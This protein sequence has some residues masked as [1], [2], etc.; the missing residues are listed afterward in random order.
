MGKEGSLWDDS[1]L[2][3]AFDHAISTYKKMDS[4]KNKHS[5]AEPERVMD[6]GT[7]LNDSS[8]EYPYYHTTRDVDKKSNVPATDAP[9]SGENTYAS[10]LEENHL[11]ESRVDLPHLDSTSSQDIQNVQN[12]YAYAQGAD[13]YNQ[14]VAKY[15]E[16]EDKKLKVLEQ[17]NQYGCSNYQYVA[18]ASGADVPHSNSQDYSNSAYQ[19]SDPNVVCTC[20][21]CYSQCLPAPCTSVPGCFLGAS[22]AGKLCD[23]HSVE[24]DHK[25]L[26]PCEDDEIHKMA[27]GAVEKAL[28][29]IRTVSGDSSANEEKENNSFEPEQINGSETDL[30]A[31]FN[32]WYSAGFYTGKYLVEQSSANKRQK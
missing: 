7:G 17:L 1:A 8:V 11:A 24:M 16:L 18:T 9:D 26:S 29:S 19:F 13:D 2:I 21:S 22:R 31:V 14:L 4:N 20:C 28:S 27:M 30:T 3:N 10:K 23:S 32:A 25:M 15:Y 5:S 12:S 6:S